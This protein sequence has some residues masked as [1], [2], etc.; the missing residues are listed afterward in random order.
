MNEDI[1]LSE[2]EMAELANLVDIPEEYHGLA[3]KE[4]L[5]SL[6]E[7]WKK[8]VLTVSHNNDVPAIAS[9]F[10]IL[11]QITKNFIK[12]ISSDILFEITTNL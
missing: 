11:G 5:P 4:K 12:N 2:E 10:T 3:L 9:F 7:D 8:T 6:V 1:T